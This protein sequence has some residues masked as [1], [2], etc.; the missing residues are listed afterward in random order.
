MIITACDKCGKARQVF[1]TTETG[2]YLRGL[3]QFEDEATEFRCEDCITGAEW[4]EEVIAPPP[5]ATG[6]EITHG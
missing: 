4:R 3:H 1:A 5:W 2:I 6:R